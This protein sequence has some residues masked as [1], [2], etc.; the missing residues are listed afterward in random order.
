MI[1]GNQDHCNPGVDKR[2]TVLVKELRP[3]LIRPFVA[4]Y[5]NPVIALRGEKIS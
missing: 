2:I 4:I 1:L 5:Q 3:F